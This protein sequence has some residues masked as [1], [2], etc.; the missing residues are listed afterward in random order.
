MLPFG[1]YAV[2]HSPEHSMWHAGGDVQGESLLVDMQ[3]YYKVTDALGIC[4]C[5][6][7][8]APTFA[9]LL[10]TFPVEPSNR[11]CQPYNGLLL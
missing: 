9:P 6:Y 2:E 8:M 11:T 10:Y 7:M 1:P 5:L 3:L 4:Y